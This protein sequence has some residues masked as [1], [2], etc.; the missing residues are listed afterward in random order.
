MT[1]SIFDAVNAA[2]AAAVH[3]V[4][5]EAATLTPMAQ[6]PAGPNAPR[7]A[8]L[9]RLPAPLPVRAI[10]AEHAARADHADNGMGRALGMVR[11]SIA[12]ARHMVSFAPGL[13]WARARAMKSN[14]RAGPARSGGLAK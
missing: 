1:G 8:D 2:S 10:L 3:G 14:L 7:V 12:G 5:A 11:Q 4:F 13:P 6:S 9:E